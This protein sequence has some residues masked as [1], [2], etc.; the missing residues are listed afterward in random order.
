MSLVKCKECS[1]EISSFAKSCP[2]CGAPNSRSQR[3]GL[4][5]CFGLFLLVLGCTSWAV[6]K[7]PSG[8]PD[9]W[10]TEDNSTMAYLM[11]EDFVT[12]RLKSPGSAEFPGI[13]ETASHTTKLDN[14]QYRISSWVDSQ[15]TFG[16]NVRTRFSGVV[17]QT[18]QD[19][20]RLVSLDF[21]D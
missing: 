21:L 4:T 14:H 19:K 3:D 17:E 8:G 15:N 1:T 2:Q 5:G 7:T 12:E 11:M 13:W 6:I 20:W 9:D 18:A 16:A 10:L